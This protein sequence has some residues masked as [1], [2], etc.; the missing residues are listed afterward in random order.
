MKLIFSL[1]LIWQFSFVLNAKETAQFLSTPKAEKLFNYEDK[2]EIINEVAND[3]KKK[4]GFLWGQS[5][6]SKDEAFGYSIMLFQ[7]SSF[8]NS[9]RTTRLL[10]F[11]K[12][13]QNKFLT[14]SQEKE[15]EI[16]QTINSEKRKI[17]QSEYE[18]W[19]TNELKNKMVRNLKLSN[20]ASG[21]IQPLA[22]GPGGGAILGAVTDASK[23]FDLVLALF[24][25][26]FDDAKPDKIKLSPATK[27]YLKNM[28]EMGKMAKLL[29]NSLNQIYPEMEEQY[30]KLQSTTSTNSVPTRSR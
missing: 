20:N 17:L 2:L 6:S 28:D 25:N 3:F 16:K 24:V 19:R 21:F 7:P 23:R 12:E 11:E 26:S 9:E 27:E 10:A 29:E 13:G 15:K 4:N 22:F 18:K 1:L 8:L 5:Y 30:R 14:N